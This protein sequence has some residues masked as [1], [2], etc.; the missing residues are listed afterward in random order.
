MRR[1]G[2]YFFLFDKNL[3]TFIFDML[4][5][6]LLL[7]VFRM[8][9]LPVEFQDRAFDATPEQLQATVRQ[10]EQYFNRQFG[11]QTTF[12]FTLAPVTTLPHETAYYGANYSD[13][14]DINL[15][16]AVRD[17]C[18]QRQADINYTLYD[19]DSDGAVDNVF[20][21]AA[22][23]GEDNGGGESAI[24]PQ[25]GRLSATG[26]PI[27]IQGKRIDRF[28]VC[29]EGR[30]G[31]FCHEFGH[32]LG[33]TDLYD[34]DGEDSGG[35]TLGLWGFSLMDE[36]CLGD[37][38]P[39]FGAL[40]Y[41]LLGLGQG[42]SLAPGH[43]ELAPLFTDR[44]YLKA[45]AQ[46]EDEFFLFEN[47]GG[48]LYVYHIDRTDNSAG[49]SARQDREL[50]AR[51][52]WE[53]GEVNNNPAHPCA[54][55]LPADPAAKDLSAVPFPQEGFD[56]F[57]SDSPTPMRAWNGYAPGLAL[58]GIRRMADGGV[59]FDVIR[60]LEFAEFSVYQDAA[61][62]RWKPSA[63]L[64]KVAGYQVSWTDGTETMIRDLG[65]EATSHTLEHLQPKTAYSVT[66]QVRTAGQERYSLSTSF[67]TKVYREGTY[68]YIYLSNA[69]RNLDGS[70]PAGSK[71]PLRV[72]NATGVEEVRWTLD[73]KLITPEAD[74][75]YTLRRSGRLAAQ[76]L[77][78]DGTTE[79]IYKEITVQ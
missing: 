44:R 76:I 26:S 58:T 37:T 9:V 77:H 56:S 25:Q 2:T 65:P 23:P 31:V 51:E 69:Q 27:S 34:T 22:G 18:N 1:K 64:G 35:R 70:F 19:N 29:S 49:A 36:G 66:V 6:P 42:E 12:E 53:L 8:I 59:A 61:V 20:L 17:A 75:N 48:S 60:P 71:I 79:T 54:R 63:D 16:E 50:T 10:A 68:P 21:L 43:Y 73:G 40:D 78:T 13:R 62:V 4:S 33:L 24:W 72:F 5:L 32:V 15:P 55:L 30:L 52:R 67:V 74:G 3:R 38:P 46:K 11:G 45:V 39:D 47:R 28:A 14:K 7:S 41:E 57:G